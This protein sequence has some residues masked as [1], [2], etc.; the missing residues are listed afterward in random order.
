MGKSKYFS[1]ITVVLLLVAI[2][3]GV[4]LVTSEENM[5]RLARARSEG[6]EVSTERNTMRAEEVSIYL[7]PSEMQSFPGMPVEIVIK[8]DTGRKGVGGFEGTLVYNA[9]HLKLAGDVI[10]GSAFSTLRSEPERSKIHF[11]GDGRMVGQ[12][13]IATVRFEAVALG[14]SFVNFDNDTM[15]WDKGKESNILFPSAVAGTM[16]EVK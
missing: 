3:M 10:A 14:Q 6:E 15:V 5:D 4:F 2:P 12:A 16:V 9:R 8:I 11:T 13:R 7:S 1:A